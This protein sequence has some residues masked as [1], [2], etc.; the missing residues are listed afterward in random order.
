[1]IV[2]LNFR[3]REMEARVDRKEDGNNGIMMMLTVPLK[4]VISSH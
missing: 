3:G 4:V 2:E 1:V